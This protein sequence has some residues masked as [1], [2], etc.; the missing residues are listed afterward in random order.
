[1]DL[2]AF[3]RTK[4]LQMFWLDE[5]LNTT[6]FY[7]GQ[8]GHKLVVPSGRSRNTN[9]RSGTSSWAIYNLRD[10]DEVTEKIWH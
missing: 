2:I 3:K 10:C 8:S 5:R 9:F 7:V 4:S 1:M 6:I